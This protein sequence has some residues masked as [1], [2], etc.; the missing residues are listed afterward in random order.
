M[1][2]DIVAFKI[3]LADLLARMAGA[4]R[5]VLEEKFRMA[6]SNAILRL[7]HRLTDARRLIEIHEECTGNARGRRHGYDALNRSA[8]IL[9]VAAWEGFSEESLER[10]VAQIA[11][12][13]KGPEVLPERVWQA[14]LAHLHEK[15]AWGKLSDKTKSSIWRLTGNGWRLHFIEYSKTKIA[16]L[17]TPN[18]TNLRKTYSSLVGLDNFSAQWGERR[19]SEAD[20]IKKLDDLLNLRHRIA[21]GGIGE[22][23]VGKRKALASVSLIERLA[24]KTDAT[25]SAHLAAMKLRHRLVLRKVRPKAGD[26]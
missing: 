6:E 18:H 2:E 17:N 1:Q 23:T 12:Q 5:Q 19:W 21:H 24:R 4:D 20:Y 7:R 16:A 13:A 9:A 22:E 8:V 3:F 15:H 14:M 10:A 25:L 26:G 11:R